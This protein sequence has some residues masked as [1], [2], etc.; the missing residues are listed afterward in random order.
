MKSLPILLLATVLALGS[1][2]GE[3]AEPIDLSKLSAKSKKNMKQIG[4]WQVGVE[5]RLGNVCF[6][7]A[8]FRDA[9]I[10]RFWL[11]ANDAGGFFILGNPKWKS[12]KS[13]KFYNI[14]FAF[15]DEP[16][17]IRE[18]KPVKTKIM[19]VLVGKDLEPKFFEEIAR[20]REM[21]IRYKGRVAARLQ[22]S[23]SYNAVKA[24]IACQKRQMVMS[25][26][27]GRSTSDP[28]DDSPTSSIPDGQQSAT[29][30]V[31]FALQSE[32]KRVGCDPGRPD[33]VWGRKGRAALATFNIYADMNLPTGAPTRQAL[34]AVKAK[35]SRVC[36]PRSIATVKK[37]PSAKR[38]DSATD[39]KLD[40]FAF[41]GCSSACF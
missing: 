41:G 12:L 28:F 25:S 31:A 27:S 23:G 20:R 24:L 3:A 11:Q 26:N 35:S 38:R 29:T 5:R 30:D 8:I 16:A 9:T 19:N 6:L 18:A 7:S 10:A 37:K 39:D 13:D 14:E 15:D 4:P 33:G 1:A 40:P 21:V 2:S 34:E 36:P 32:L 17:W 22:L